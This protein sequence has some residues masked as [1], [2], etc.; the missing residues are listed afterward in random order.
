MSYI[1]IVIKGILVGVANL[2]PGVSGGTMAVSLAIYDDLIFA[3]TH[4]KKAFKKSMSILLPLALGIL[5]GIVFFSYAIEVLLSQY[6]FPTAMAFVGL[7]LGGL[8]ILL[9]QF[10]HTL[11]TERESIGWSQLVVFTLFFAL[12]VV[13]SF[14]QESD[15]TFEALDLTLANLAI[16][17]FVGLIAAATMVIPGI[18]GSLVLMILG[19]YYNI[20]NTLTNFF[21]ALRSL[22]TQG[23]LHGLALL[24][25]FGLGVLVGI[26]L[27]S[28][29]IEYLFANQPV[30]TYSGIF[31]L[32]LASPIAILLNTGA[33]A[34]LSS[35]PVDQMIRFVST[36]GLLLALCFIGTYWLGQAGDQSE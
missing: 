8:P 5:L 25:P 33:I 32:V 10:A 19:Y 28:K 3:I 27:I 17:F 15:V 12:I 21:D 6:T 11:K 9:R 4:L 7:V 14:Y 20:I 13:L 34:S 29:I 22:D 24:I 31:G 23:I 18:S 16:L 2:I 36:G 26:F 30:L 1:W 35:L